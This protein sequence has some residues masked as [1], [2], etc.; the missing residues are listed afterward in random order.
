MIKAEVRYTLQ[1]FEE[2]SKTFQMVN[3]TKNQKIYWI[4]FTIICHI[5][6]FIIAIESHA[7]FNL[8]TLF[9]IFIW[10]CIIANILFKKVMFNPAR[11]FRKFNEAN[12]DNEM[13][14][15]FN[16][17]S[18]ILISKTTISNTTNE[19]DYV[20]IQ[21]IIETETFFLLNLKNIGSFAIGKNEITQ[22]SSQKLA[23]LLKLSCNANYVI[24]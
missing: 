22:G 15:E 21:E 11:N 7:Y 19:Y 5:L 13:W 18:L 9:S 4:L 14:F 10:I 12:P 23:E 2:F 8:F 1:H 16:E 3:F 24:K 17:K 20:L 6:A